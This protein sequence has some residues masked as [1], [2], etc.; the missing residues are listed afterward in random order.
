MATDDGT[1]TRFFRTF[2]LRYHRH[3]FTIHNMM[4]KRTPHSQMAYA[5]GMREVVLHYVTLFNFRPPF[6]K[7]IFIF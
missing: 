6:T 3:V 1:Q 5:A 4:M 7:S 2:Y